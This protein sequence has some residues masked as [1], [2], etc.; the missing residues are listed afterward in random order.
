MKTSNVVVIKRG[1]NECVKQFAALLAPLFTLYN[2]QLKKQQKQALR[3][4]MCACVCTYSAEKADEED[5]DAL[6]AALDGPKKEA[7]TAAAAAA[8][9]AAVPAAEAAAATEA[10]A[11][12][13]AAKEGAEEE[14]E[15]GCVGG[16]GC[17]GGGWNVCMYVCRSVGVGVGANVLVV[18][19]GLRVV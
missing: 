8:G 9:G 10:G 3:P 14:E 1:K 16:V 2:R 7:A 19:V 4:H 6:L 18:G 17:R 13:A 11:E 5:I 12:E 15:G